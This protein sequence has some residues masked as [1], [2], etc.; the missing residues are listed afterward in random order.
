M[1]PGT[2]A[3]FNCT[4]DRVL[5]VVDLS[6]SPSPAEPDRTTLKTSNV[7]LEAADRTALH[8]DEFSGVQCNNGKKQEPVHKATVVRCPSHPFY[9]PL[10]CPPL[11]TPFHFA[12][13]HPLYAMRHD[14]MCHGTSWPRSLNL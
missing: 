7:S 11:C 12:P 1:A 3:P 8:F 9:A 13:V 4:P 10:S 5:I 6:L 2:F 14:A